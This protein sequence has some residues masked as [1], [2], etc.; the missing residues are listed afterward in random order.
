MSRTDDTRRSWDACAERYDRWYGT[1][2]GA[3]EHQVDWT[4]LRAHLPESR[5]ARILDAAGGT[6]R[7]A[8]PLARMGYP[9]TLADISPGMLEVARRKLVE[10]DLADRVEIVEC[11][12]A[13]LGFADESF[14]LVIC[15]DGMSEH[16]ARELVRVAKRGGRLSL[17]LTNRIGVAIE[18]FAER[19]EEALALL[20]SPWSETCFD[21]DGFAHRP[22]A[23]S[24]EEAKF[25]F[26]RQGVTVSVI[27]AVCGLLR[28]L[29]IP[30]EIRKSREWDAELFR[31]TGE[32][33][34]CLS[35]EPSAK[36]F[37]RHLVVC[38]ERSAKP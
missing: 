22:L 12:I 19:P 17:Y 15:W 16:A 38:G 2:E 18:R 26:E 10:E 13:E 34:V 33:L 20:R 8:V 14:D 24:V 30:D 4:L 35:D 37:S 27:H 21:V 11:D 9:V 1:F 3:V 5:S 28:L 7:A 6:G 32:M 36:G 31:R 25:F 29:S 23:M